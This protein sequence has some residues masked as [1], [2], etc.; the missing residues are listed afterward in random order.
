[1]EPLLKLEHVAKE[2]E[3]FQLSDINLQLPK[4]CIMGLIGD[5]GAG[6]TTIMKA[7]LGMLRISEG[8]IQIFHK[9]LK[10]DEK[11]IKEKIGSVFAEACFPENMTARQIHKTLSSIYQD[12]DEKAYFSYLNVFH[13]PLDKSN[14]TFSRGMK[15]KLQIAIALSH[16]AQLLLLDEATSGLDP[17]AREEILDI[18]LDF[19]QDEEHSVLISSHITTDIEK[20]CDYVTFLHDGKIMLSGEKDALLDSYGIWHCKETDLSFLRPEEYIGYRK[21]AYAFDI[22]VKDRH[23]IQQRF[24][25][26]VLDP[27]TL[28]DI[29]VFMVKGANKS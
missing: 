29:L 20:C 3:Q 27:A 4:G 26:A 19:I 28:E 15:M 22:M 5:N 23:A 18:L 13:L 10:S 24:N 11:G 17:V 14:K 8:N 25:E 1:M 21:S 6:K 12:W 9:D 7:I 2:Y 16:H